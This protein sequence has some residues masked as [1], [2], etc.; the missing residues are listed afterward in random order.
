MTLTTRKWVLSAS[1]VLLSLA[2]TACRTFNYTEEDMARERRL[3]DEGLVNCRGW[4]GGSVG[5]AISPKIDCG[6]I[7]IGGVGGA[8]A[9]R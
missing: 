5:A 4:P 3:I 1:L 9:G 6:A 8:C 2:A 7:N